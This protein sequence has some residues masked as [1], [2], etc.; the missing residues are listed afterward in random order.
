[1]TEQNI[2]ALSNPDLANQMVEQAMAT[3]PEEMSDV[4]VI[5]PPS[6]NMVALP[7]GHVT[8]TGEVITTAEVRE[9]TGKTRKLLPVRVVAQNL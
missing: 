1:M 6:E 5:L 2:S 8:F 9:L 3:A 7:G 4:E